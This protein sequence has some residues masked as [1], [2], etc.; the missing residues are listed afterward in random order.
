MF[1]PGVL[2]YIKSMVAQSLTARCDIA[3]RV[4][5]KTGAGIPSHV[6][7][8]VASNVPCRI[9]EPRTKSATES[10]RFANQDVI[11]EPYRLIVAADVVLNVDARITVD[12]VRYYVTALD[13]QLTDRV[14]RSC[15]IQWKR[16]SDGE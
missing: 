5:T 8:D 1:P 7:V 3:E 15:S 6:W 2:G 16:G 9:I 11:E 10:E 4:V 13:T 14:Y 12:G